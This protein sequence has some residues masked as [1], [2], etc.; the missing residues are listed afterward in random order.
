MSLE[1]CEKFY[2]EEFRKLL[3]NDMFNIPEILVSTNENDISN[4]FNKLSL[5]N[6]HAINYPLIIPNKE[7]TD[8]IRFYKI[9]QPGDKVLI[10]NYQF[11]VGHLTTQI[12]TK[13]G[14]SFSVGA[15]SGAG[16]NSV[17]NTP[18]I[19]FEKSLIK[20]CFNPKSKYTKLIAI[21]ELNNKHI[22]EIYKIFDNAKF[23]DK[24][25]KYYY[26]NIKLRVNKIYNERITNIHT[27]NIEKLKHTQN[28]SNMQSNTQS[29]IKQFEHYKSTNKFYC[30]CPVF[31]YNWMDKYFCVL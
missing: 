27:K 9:L 13:N 31:I 10:W 12:I 21:S 29:I 18:D 2:L 30:I 28:D 24:N 11:A 1:D 5:V 16:Y 25:F 26:T 15:F 20:Q 23:S 8:F 17:L 19:R 14:Y 6:I 4:I 22:R 3:L 7:N